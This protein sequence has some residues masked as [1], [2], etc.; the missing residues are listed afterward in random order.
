MTR[1]REKQASMSLR[2]RVEIIDSVTD[3]TR[4]HST[5]HG[6]SRYGA[7]DNTVSTHDAAG[8][9]HD[10]FRPAQDQ[11]A[12]ADP[13][14]VFDA[15]LANYIRLRAHRHVKALLTMSRVSNRREFAHQHIVADLNAP[16]TVDKTAARD[17][18]TI[19]DGQTSAALPNAPDFEGDISFDMAVLTNLQLSKEGHFDIAADVCSSA[20]YCAAKHAEGEPAHQAPNGSGRVEDVKLNKQQGSLLEQQ[21]P[22]SNSPG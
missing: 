10:A 4:G 16:R 22:Q 7:C 17:P 12:S 6:I 18:D 9:E 8:T 1:R 11:A 13:H 19:A 2:F 5:P 3:E 14:V 15:N 21:R 20:E